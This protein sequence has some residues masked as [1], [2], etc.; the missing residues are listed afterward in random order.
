MFM[1]WTKK[2]AAA[3]V[4]WKE[5]AAVAALMAS[6]QAHAALPEMQSSGNA[7]EG[8]F[9]QMMM[10]YAGKAFVVLGIVVVAA[11][12]MAVGR[13]ALGVYAE[14]GDGRKKWSDLGVHVLVG[15]CLLVVT[16]FLAHQAV[17]VFDDVSV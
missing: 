16:V 11:A 1:Q 4:K 12:F 3:A 15:G 17:N 10:E 7:E 5:A 8:N 2:A 14:I 13:N 6:V 9:L